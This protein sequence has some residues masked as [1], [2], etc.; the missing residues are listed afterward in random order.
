MPHL[1]ILAGSTSQSITVFIQDSS[2]SYPKGLAGL[3]YNTASLTAYYCFANTVSAAIS[4]VTLAAANSA[5]SSGGFKEVDG[6][7]MPGVYRLDL[8][9]AVLAASSGRQVTIILKGATN[10]ANCVVS[11]ELT[12]WNNQDGVRG[13]M[14]ALPNAAAAAS[15]GLLINGSNTGTVTLAALTV[16][17]N[18]TFTGTTAHTGEVTMAAGLAITQSQSN[19][20][21]LSVTG[22][23]TGHGVAFIS[24]SGTTGNGLNVSAASTN[25]VGLNIAGVG[26]GAGLV[27]TGGA[28]G[29]GVKF[30]GGST[31]GDGLYAAGATL[32]HGIN[33]IGAGSGKHGIG[34][35]LETGYDFSQGLQLILAACAGKTSISSGTVTIRDVADSANRIV[36]VTD[37]DGQRSSVS[38]TV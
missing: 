19:T 17:G 30:V 4:L 8:P 11:I 7:N 37:G 20:A 22:N 35:T 2:V 34:G 33:P 18:T 24:G 14:T 6:T 27:S 13:G 12:G 5:W 38:L 25:G 3:A 23:G 29:H 1:S 9:N 32:G 31:S 10:M 15:G 26:T 36:A 16:S 28:T 21:G